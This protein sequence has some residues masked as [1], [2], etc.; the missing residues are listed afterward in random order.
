MFEIT[1]IIYDKYLFDFFAQRWYFRQKMNFE[2]YNWFYFWSNAF[3][4]LLSNKQ[5]IMKLILWLSACWEKIQY[6]LSV[7]IWLLFYGAWWQHFSA[8]SS[9]SL[10][11]VLIKRRQQ[12][13]ETQ[14]RTRINLRAAAENYYNENRARKMG[15]QS[16]VPFEVS[17]VNADFAH[18]RLRIHP[19]AYLLE[20][21]F[22]WLVT[23]D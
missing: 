7:Y 22:A 11:L 12:P 4:L 8:M 20:C 13:A 6:L 23:G 16:A 9:L 19:R 1:S 14:Q 3:F 5:L 15:Q 2:F 21:I 10:L 17:R 18:F